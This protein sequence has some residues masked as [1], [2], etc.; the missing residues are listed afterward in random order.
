MPADQILPAHGSHWVY[1]WYFQ[2]GAFE[3]YVQWHGVGS[4]WKGILILFCALGDFVRT[5][6]SGA[7]NHTADSAPTKTLRWNRPAD[8]SKCD[9]TVLDLESTGATEMQKA[10]GM[11]W[12]DA[13]RSFGELVNVAPR[14]DARPIGSRHRVVI[15]RWRTLVVAKL[16][17]SYVRRA[18]LSVDRTTAD[19][20]LGLP[21]TA[22]LRRTAG[23]IGD[24]G[25]PGRRSWSTW[26]GPGTSCSPRWAHPGR[27]AHW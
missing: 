11:A 4:R 13:G 22:S 1:P 9:L 15:I 14:V 27:T 10:S 26:G 8:R 21:I 24:T 17:S 20:R 6:Q 7:G 18:E 19:A 3:Q 25:P 5:G 16:P 12:A 23:T 2:P